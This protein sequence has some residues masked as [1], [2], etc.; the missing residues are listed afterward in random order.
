MLAFASSRNY[1]GASLLGLLLGVLVIVPLLLGGCSQSIPSIQTPPKIITLGP[2]QL[3]IDTV[4]FGTV[5]RFRTKDTTL[6]FRLS[7]R[8]TL[9]NILFSDSSW[10]LKEGLPVMTSSDSVLSIQIS[11]IAND[12]SVA[13]GLAILLRNSDTIG[14]IFLS[15]KSG[16]FEHRVG[17][18]YVFENPPGYKLDTVTVIS[19]G[20][21]CPS[22]YSYGRLGDWANPRLDSNG[23]LLIRPYEDNSGPARLPVQTG[24]KFSQGYLGG[25]RDGDTSCIVRGKKFHGAA[26]TLTDIY[27][28]YFGPHGSESAAQDEVVH[29]IYLPELGYYG[30]VVG[31]NTYLD[32][33]SMSHGWQSSGVDKTLVYYHLEP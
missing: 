22:S 21:S 4:D 29:M 7:Q 25:T 28:Q 6:R 18:Y 9:T 24:I 5:S 13:A 3:F 23:D 1:F 30:R 26:V 17:D 15:A 14:L 10:T 12:S 2:P 31:S 32:Q 27:S 20:F 33:G 19:S 8:D 16:P 11:Y